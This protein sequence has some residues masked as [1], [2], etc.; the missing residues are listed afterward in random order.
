MEAII[1][2]LKE[3]VKKLRR[4]IQSIDYTSSDCNLK[5]TKFEKNRILEIRSKIQVLNEILIEVE[6]PF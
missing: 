5:L 4:E 6:K 3:K 1:S 2:I